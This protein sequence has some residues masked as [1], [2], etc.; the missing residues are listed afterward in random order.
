MCLA[1]VRSPL[2]I[3]LAMRVIQNSTVKIAN[4]PLTCANAGRR[5]ADKGLLNNP[6]CLVMD[7]RRRGPPLERSYA[8]HQRGAPPLE[9]WLDVLG[10]VHPPL[11]QFRGVYETSL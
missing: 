7:C 11:D 9:A 6:R 1:A 2:G 5:D 10:A 3:R 8:E 4:G